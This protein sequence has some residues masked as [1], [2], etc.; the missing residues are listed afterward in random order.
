M[1]HL[2]VTRISRIAIASIALTMAS[3][4]YA[5]H[6][7]DQFATGTAVS[8]TGVI[9]QNYDRV[10]NTPGSHPKTAQ[11]KSGKI[12]WRLRKKAIQTTSR[13]E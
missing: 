5:P 3:S 2:F 8:S 1:N 11:F 9:R 12:S 4:A 6:P 7:P 13:A 10:P